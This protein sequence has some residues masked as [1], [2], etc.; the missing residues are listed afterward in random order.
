MTPATL[1][2]THKCLPVVSAS[3]FVADLSMRHSSSSYTHLNTID[4]HTN[5]SSMQARSRGTM[6]ARLK[7][8]IHFFWL[9]LNGPA[10]QKEAL[11]KT[12]DP[13][14]VDFLA[15]LVYNFLHHFPISEKERK[16]LN[17]RRFLP[18][19]ASIKRSVKARKTMIV[20]HRRQFISTLI[21]HHSKLNSLIQETL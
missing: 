12:A 10:R 9:L 20:N 19:I 1:T 2:K 17:R 15:E 5:L 14:Q 6:S 3:G 11:L 21:E 18:K 4:I 13:E 8:N 7:A 16:A